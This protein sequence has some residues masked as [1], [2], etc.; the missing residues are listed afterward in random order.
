MVQKFQKKSKEIEMS[1][2]KEVVNLQIDVGVLKQQVST[3]CTLCDKMDKVMEKL[4]DQHDRHI[5]KIYTDM[6]NRRLETE[7]DI[8][9]IHVRIDTVLDKLQDSELRLMDE[10]KAMRKDMQDHNNKE[11]E[12]LDKLLQWKWMVVGGV[13]V[14]SWIISRVNLDTFSNLF[15]K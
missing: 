1:D 4:V 12:S 2:D 13:I 8:K 9:E 10:L 11:K 7:A 6:D 14:F 5:A 15:G 3:L